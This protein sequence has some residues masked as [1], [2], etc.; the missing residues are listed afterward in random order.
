MVA[1]MNVELA[2]GVTN[3][4]RDRIRVD[5]EVLGQAAG[6]IG[7]GFRSRLVFVSDGNQVSHGVGPLSGVRLSM[8]SPPITVDGLSHSGRAK[9]PGGASERP[10][11]TR[12]PLTG[13]RPRQQVTRHR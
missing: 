11:P 12:R 13:G 8:D 10:G 2:L 9:P 4:D 1:G 5:G 3:D 7:G 6:L